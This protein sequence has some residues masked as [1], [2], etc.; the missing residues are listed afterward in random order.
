MKKRPMSTDTLALR[1]SLPADESASRT[2]RLLA[3]AGVG[4]ERAFEELMLLHR[5]AVYR[6]ALGL[7]GNPED[8]ADVCQDVFI[9]FY[10]HLRKLRAEWGVAAWL[11]RVTVHRCY[12]VL[13]ARKRAP[14]QQLLSSTNKISTE[15]SSDSH[16]ISRDITKG[17]EALSPR[18]R[19]AF[20]LTCHQGY[21]S[22]DAGKA[23]G[24][25]PAT[26]RVLV[27]RARG[28]LRQFLGET[29]GGKDR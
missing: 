28:K 23:M 18:E 15:T 9:R 27:L 7:T 14:E 22:A 24:C 25:R 21:S 8:A 29:S 12:D 20:I 10:R 16:L 11:R 2:A 6:L 5:A 17:L 3:E 19:A 13:K 26:V 1:Q 4:N